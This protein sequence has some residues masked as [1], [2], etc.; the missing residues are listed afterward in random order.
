MSSPDGEK[1]GG[2]YENAARFTALILLLV[3]VPV[4]WAQADPP[5]GRGYCAD[6]RQAGAGVISMDFGRLC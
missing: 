1:T 2:H 4:V 6:A 5:G 3:T